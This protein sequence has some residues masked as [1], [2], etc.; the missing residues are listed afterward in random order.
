MSNA[1]DSAFPVPRQVRED[2]EVLAYA[3]PGLTKREYAAI[4]I[5]AS[6]CAGESEADGYWRDE[7][8]A[9]RAVARA[10]ALLAELAKVRP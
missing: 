3:E 6:M 8:L 10:D 2:G 4:Q 1:T 9:K 5:A 7:T